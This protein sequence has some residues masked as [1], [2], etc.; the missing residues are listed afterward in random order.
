LIDDGKLRV[1]EKP[2][3]FQ[4]HAVCMF[5][6]RCCD[7]DLGVATIYDIN[8]NEFRLTTTPTEDGRL[9]SGIIGLV[10][11]LTSEL[12][13]DAK[14]RAQVTVQETPESWVY[15]PKAIPAND[16]TFMA[17]TGVFYGDKEV[18]TLDGREIFNLKPNWREV[19]SRSYDPNRM[20]VDYGRGKRSAYIKARPE[21]TM[22]GTYTNDTFYIID[23]F[24]RHKGRR[25][26]FLFYPDLE[27]IPV[28]ST[29][30]LDAT[31]SRIHL[32]KPL[33]F[34]Q[35]FSEDTAAYVTAD[36]ERFFKVKEHSYST[37]FDIYG[38]IDFPIQ[39]V[40]WSWAYKAR[41]ASDK[42]EVVWKN[43]RVAEV[44]V[45]VKLL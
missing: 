20:V 45:S 38:D 8:G 19:V 23:F 16:T 13:V 1:E 26:E 2:P 18:L 12:Y 6:Q 27:E 43:D 37:Y 5:G 39:G 4:D 41:F 17:H 36:G 30:S 9:F 33:K 14:G 21:V 29:E 32:P 22:K 10:D 24:M 28:V 40:K 44:T 11:P 15:T 7:Q 42:L 31:T 34:G 25:T 3:W 35:F